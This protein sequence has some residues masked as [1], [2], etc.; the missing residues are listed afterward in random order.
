MAFPNGNGDGDRSGGPVVA[1]VVE[2]IKREI[3]S[4]RLKSGDRIPAESELGAI[5]NVSRT[6]VREAMKI[7]DS[8]TV[9]KVRRGDGT[10]VAHP[11]EISFSMPW[12]FKI[13]L[14]DVTWREVIE[15]RGQIE[16]MV[17][18]SAIAHASEADVAGLEKIVD[19]MDEYC[20]E[21]PSDYEGI[22]RLDMEFH[23]ALVKLAR[24][25]FIEAVYEF[26]YQTIAPLIRKNYELLGTVD[27][28]RLVHRPYLHAIRNRDV[29]MAAYLCSPSRTTW[30]KMALQRNVSHWPFAAEEMAEGFDI[31]PE[32]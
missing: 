11:D 3:F 8:L 13:R 14:S 29:M 21:H 7:L 15:F 5:L 26:T 25:M 4:G 6:A 27:P 2:Y 12:L 30:A 22:Y 28:K 10:Y 32:A 17:L 31:P 16:F 20:R 24:N 19:M 9:L 1:K 23:A 18:K